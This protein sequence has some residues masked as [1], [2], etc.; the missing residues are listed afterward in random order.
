MARQ[1]PGALIELEQDLALV[2]LVREWDF[3][4]GKRFE[5][6]VLHKFS[7]LVHHPSSSP[8]G[9][10]FLLV[11]FRRF[12]FRLTED[13]VAL[14]LHCCL[15]GAPAGFHVTYQSDCHFRFSVASKHVGLL[16]RSLRRITTAHFDVYFH[17][18]LWR[19]GGD[20]WELE[21]RWDKEEEASW[22]TVLS[23]KNKRKLTSK[24]V[25]FCSKLIQ[26][27]P[28]HKSCPTEIGL[29]IK[30][31]KFFCPITVSSSSDSV[32]S[33]ADSGLGRDS[34]HMPPL[35]I[36]QASSGVLGVHDVNG[37]L[38]VH[39]VQSAPVGT[40]KS[41]TSSTEGSRNQGIFQNIKRDLHINSL[42]D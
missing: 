13:S 34:E 14:A 26:D 10:F 42:P 5:A 20:N 35:E 2:E 6:E 18:H 1:P 8:D 24:N 31:G 23:P 39:I 33:T 19:G 9:S 12:L 37:E 28:A 16:I 27:S 4:P 11:V 36:S 25:S 3:S 15:G 30:I 32:C 21:K 17:F 40:R 29:V 22:T 7:S 38:D 41:A